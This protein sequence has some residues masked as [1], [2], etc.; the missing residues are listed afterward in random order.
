MTLSPKK[1]SFE[2]LKIDREE[3]FDMTVMKERLKAEN[4]DYGQTIFEKDDPKFSSPSMNLRIIHLVKS[5]ICKRLV[6]GLNG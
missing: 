5:P 1:P 2:T 4:T 6:T 3:E